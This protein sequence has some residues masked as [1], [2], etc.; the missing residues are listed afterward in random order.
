MY[1]WIK[2]TFQKIFNYIKYVFTH[3]RDVL[4]P[5][6]LAEMIFWSPV[7]VSALLAIII[8]P[9]WWTVAGGA[10]AFWA[11]PFTPAIPLQIGLIALFERCWNKI[12]KRRDNK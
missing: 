12:R 8:S 4:F 11:G 6:I 1:E 9:W 2:K 3:P 10:I 7:W 5:F